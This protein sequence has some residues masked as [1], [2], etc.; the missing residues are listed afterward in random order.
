MRHLHCGLGVC[1]TASHNP[2]EYNG[3]KV[4]GADGCQMTPEA[5]KRVV[6][7]LEHGLFASA[8][9]AGL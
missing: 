1:V 4:Y 5:A 7:L 8:K 9:T 2:A 6:A 3:Y